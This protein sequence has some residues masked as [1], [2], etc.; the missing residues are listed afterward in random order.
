MDKFSYRRGIWEDGH[1]LPKSEDDEEYEAY[2]ERVGY[3][4]KAATFGHDDANQIILYEH[5]SDGSF[6][7]DVSFTN[8]HCF[9]VFLPDFPSAMQFIKDHSASFSADEANITQQEIFT[10]LEK[11]FRAQ[12]GHAS[13]E[14]C[15][16]CDPEGWEKVLQMRRNRLNDR[17]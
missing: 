10:L 7:A 5:A 8:G 16:K 17:L 9:E 14:I 11:L 3:F 15:A 1:S 4:S 6:F 12:H 2:R 13:H